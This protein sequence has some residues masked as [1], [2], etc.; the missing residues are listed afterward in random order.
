MEVAWAHAGHKTQQ[1][2]ASGQSKP[3]PPPGNRN[4]AGWVGLGHRLRQVAVSGP[5]PTASESGKQGLSGYL[6]R[7]ANHP[8]EESHS[9]MR[10]VVPAEQALAPNNITKPGK[11]FDLEDQPE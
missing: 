2:F 7:S 8:A 6:T 10:I 1:A 3:N 5:S 4:C 11:V 9:T